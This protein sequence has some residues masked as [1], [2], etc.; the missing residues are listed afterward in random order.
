MIRNKGGHDTARWTLV[1][2]EATHTG[3]CRMLQVGILLK[4]R[5]FAGPDAKARAN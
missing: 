2:N 1:E 5:V 4:P 3:I